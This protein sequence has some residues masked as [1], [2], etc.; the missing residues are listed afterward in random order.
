MKISIGV[1]C[2]CIV[3]FALGSAQAQPARPVP[4]D[5]QAQPAQPVAGERDASKD[6]VFIVTLKSPERRT[7]TDEELVRD[8]DL[9]PNNLYRVRTGGYIGFS[10]KDWIDRIEFK[11]FPKP[12]VELPEYQR[13]SKL[14]VDINQKIWQIKQTLAKYDLLALRLVNLCDRSKFSTLESIDDNIVQQ[15]TVYRRLTL[16]RSL[17]VNALNRVVTERACRDLYNNYQTTLNIYTKQLSEL[18]K[19]YTRLSRRALMLIKDT[20]TESE[21]ARKRSEKE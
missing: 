20:P 10:E 19:N 9:N 7:M 14:L 17:V 21:K 16:L 6:G 15:L 18:T 11:A 8:R 2:C 12:V 4:G 5:A 1:V 3:A 13:F